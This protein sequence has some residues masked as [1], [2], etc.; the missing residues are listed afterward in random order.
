MVFGPEE[1][2]LVRNLSLVINALKHLKQVVNWLCIGEPTNRWTILQLDQI[3]NCATSV[4]GR[5][6]H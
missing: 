6:M 3:F 2:V 4:T 1:S 5:T